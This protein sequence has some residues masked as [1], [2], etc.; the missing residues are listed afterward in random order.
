WSQDGHLVH[1][2]SGIDA[3]R[4]LMMFFLSNS[5]SNQLI[6]KPLCP[7]NSNLHCINPL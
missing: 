7:N 5:F 1:T 2:P 6:G 4:V 3:L